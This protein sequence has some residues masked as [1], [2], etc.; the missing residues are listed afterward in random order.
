MATGY[1]ILTI[2]LLGYPIS[3]TYNSLILYVKRGKNGTWIIPIG[4]VAIHF[5]HK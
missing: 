2:A 3:Y 1:S 5:S 4:L